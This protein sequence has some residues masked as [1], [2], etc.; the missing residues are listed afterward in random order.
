MGQDGIA[1]RWTEPGIS[2][3]AAGAAGERGGGG[4]SGDYRQ[5]SRPSKNSGLALE[6]AVITPADGA[7]QHHLLDQ[8]LRREYA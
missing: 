1:M 6:R 2:T 5:V 7:D 3:G 8:K 4:R